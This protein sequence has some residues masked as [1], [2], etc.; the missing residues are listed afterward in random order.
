MRRTTVRLDDG[1]LRDAKALAAQ[2]GRTLTAVL[3]EALRNVLYH[4][5]SISERAPVAL[6][7]FKGDGT[8]PGV[9]IDDSAA[10]ADLMDH[11]GPA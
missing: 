1:L 7:V 4:R 2:S 6:P 11:G 10:L 3:E 8:L 5:P 9:D